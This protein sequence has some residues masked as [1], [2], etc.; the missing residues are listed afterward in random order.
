MKIND[1]M[2]GQNSGMVYALKIAKEKGIEALEEE[3]KYRDVTNIPNQIAR[4]QADQAIEKIKLNTID[5][6]LIMGLSV[7]HDEF[8]FGKVRCERFRDRFMLKT[9]CLVDDYVSWDDMRAALENEIGIKVSIREN[10]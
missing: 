6:I 2:N 3:C 4:K 10:K 5:T 7:L 1:Y 9:D 8:D